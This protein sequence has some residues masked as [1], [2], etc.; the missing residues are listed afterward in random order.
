MKEYTY[1]ING[2]DYRVSVEG[3]ENNV[4]AVSVNG[5]A[6]QVK[7]PAEE[8]PAPRPTVVKP[9]ATAA[10]PTAKKYGVKAPLPG[11]IVEV[12]VKVGDEVKR[13]DTV[14]VLD[15]MKME[16]NIASERAGRVAQVC[17]EPGQ[18]VMEGT[19]LVVFE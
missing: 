16:N 19:D 3:I 2:T 10:A 12:T 13:G 7:L 18:S 11:V 14:V 17:V 15:A 1:N 8:A 5:I 6:Y 9:A 4:A